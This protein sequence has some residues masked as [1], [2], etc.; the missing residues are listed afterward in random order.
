MNSEGWAARRVKKS[1]TGK[2]CF[3]A[4]GAGGTSRKKTAKK[5]YTPVKSTAGNVTDT[6]KKKWNYF[7]KHKL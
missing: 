7:N 4:G 6:K 3:I 5:Q 2:D 1:R